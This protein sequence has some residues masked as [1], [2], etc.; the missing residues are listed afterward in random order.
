MVTWRL[1][2][3]KNKDAAVPRPYSYLKNVFHKIIL[4]QDE[5]S[6][7]IHVLSQVLSLNLSQ[8]SFRSCRCQCYDSLL[9]TINSSFAI[10]CICS[11]IISSVWHTPLCTTSEYPSVLTIPPHTAEFDVMSLTSFVV[12]FGVDGKLISYNSTDRVT[13]PTVFTRQSHQVC[14]IVI[15]PTH[16]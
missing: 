4:L 16:I 15:F 2:K 3:K 12:T 10:F 14:N 8:T 7:R 11:D 5:L 9:F 13:N 6:N 1:K